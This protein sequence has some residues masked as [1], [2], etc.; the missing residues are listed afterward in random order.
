MVVRVTHPTRLLESS[1]CGMDEKIG[2]EGLEVMSERRIEVGTDT[3]DKTG[4]KTWTYSLRYMSSALLNGSQ[5]AEMRASQ[6]EFTEV[7]PTPQMRTFHETDN[8][9]ASRSS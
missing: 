3:T 8:T 4:E 7:A 1:A 5:R 9:D 2:L 6:N